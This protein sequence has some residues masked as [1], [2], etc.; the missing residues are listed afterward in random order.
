MG[1]ATLIVT[2][3]ASAGS[4]VVDAFGR[5][6]H[7]V[8]RVSVSA[9]PWPLW[10]REGV[11]PHRFLVLALAFFA[12]FCD[13]LLKKSAKTV[14][15]SEL[16]VLLTGAV[17]LFKFLNDKDVFQKFYTDALAKRLVNQKSASDDAEGS[18]ISKLKVC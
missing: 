3:S 11:T 8:R 1:P 10:G 6:Y 4:Q 7:Q 14:E 15:E 18:M 13:S 2:V 5:A 16:E 17:T 12:R 9:R